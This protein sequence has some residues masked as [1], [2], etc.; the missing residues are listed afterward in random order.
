MKR[1]L[2]A[3]TIVYP[4]PVFIVGSYDAAGKPNAMTAAW[5]G[6]CCSQP[7]CV[8][9]SLRDSR[10][11]YENII[12]R[13]AFTVSIPS[14]A[15]AKEADYFGIV[16]GRTVDKF[17]A[18]GLTPVPSDVVDAPYVGE[19]PFAL[20]CRL[21]QTV[22]IGVHIQLIGEIL[23]IK[24]DEAVLDEKGALDIEKVRPIL[25]A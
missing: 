3:K 19:F 22:E 1:S 8:A 10:Y 17:A 16:S 6:I 14:E 2:G 13:Q 12:A 24:A 5:A 18:S 11:S 4:T 20:E 15:Y 9:V 21:L 25:F 23:D 7:P